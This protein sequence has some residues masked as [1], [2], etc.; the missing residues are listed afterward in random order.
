MSQAAPGCP[1]RRPTPANQPLGPRWPATQ[2]LGL[3]W[4]ATQTL[5]LRWPALQALLSTKSMTHAWLER[6]PGYK[7]SMSGGSDGSPAP[8]SRLHDISSRLSDHTSPS[9]VSVF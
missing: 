9:V 8:S 2:A 1:E 7:G 4:P 5:G 6:W 3:R